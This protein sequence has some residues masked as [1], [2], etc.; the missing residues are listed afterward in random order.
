[1]VSD[2]QKFTVESVDE[3]FDVNSGLVM[4]RCTGNSDLPLFNLPLDV[5]SY[6]AGRRGVAE[7]LGLSVDDLNLVGMTLTLDDDGV[8]SLPPD[9]N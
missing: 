2:P 9:S 8:L 7:A 3:F 6:Q 4:I 5:E 1:M